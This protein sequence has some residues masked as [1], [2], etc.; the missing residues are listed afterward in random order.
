MWCS[1]WCIGVHERVLVRKPWC[2][3][4]LIHW[5][6]ASP[7]C[8]W[9]CEPP[10]GEGVHASPCRSTLLH[11][12]AGGD[13]FACHACGAV[14]HKRDD[15]AGEQHWVMAGA[16]DWVSVDRGVDCERDRDQVSGRCRLTLA[17]MVNA[18]RPACLCVSM[19]GCMQCMLA[20]C[21]Q[22]GMDEY[23][24]PCIS[25]CCHVS[26]L[27]VATLGTFLQA[28]LCAC[29]SF[30]AAYRYSDVMFIA[31]MPATMPACNHARRLLRGVVHTMAVCLVGFNYSRH[32]LRSR[33]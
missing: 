15:V 3:T 5:L 17:H 31:A 13:C 28:C 16:C 14:V 8:Q 26:L 30:A 21:Q 24:C 32:D 22:A 12:L 29:T 4:G 23:A 27:G 6:H 25:H 10:P 9:W 2:I 19:H 20:V 18:G 1:E 11:A 7:P 33:T